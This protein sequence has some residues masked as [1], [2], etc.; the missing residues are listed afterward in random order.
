MGTA[1]I[2]FKKNRTAALSTLWLGISGRAVF[3]VGQALSCERGLVTAC[4][5]LR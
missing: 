4:Y 5:P 2:R 3:L 1:K